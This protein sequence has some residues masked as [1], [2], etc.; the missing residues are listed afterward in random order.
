MRGFFMAVGVL[1]MGLTGLCSGSM[2]VGSLGDKTFF[3]TAAI[4]LIVGGIPFV[5]GLIIY[6]A[7]KP[8]KR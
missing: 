3:S 2:I 8:K 7:A 1:I 4:A 6:L 5:V